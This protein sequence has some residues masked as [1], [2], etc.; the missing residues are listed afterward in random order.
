MDTQN[1][2]VSAFRNDHRSCEVRDAVE[3]VRLLQR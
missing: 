2:A 3:S 1:A